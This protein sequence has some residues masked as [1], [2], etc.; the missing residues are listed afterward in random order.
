MKDMQELNKHSF[1]KNM[2]FA[3]VLSIAIVIC[4][5]VMLIFQINSNLGQTAIT[6][7]AIV[8]G[9][10]IIPLSYI[11]TI[12]GQKRI[13]KKH[14]F[15]KGFAYEYEFNKSYFNLRAISIESN[16]SKKIDYSEIIYISKRKECMYL[17]VSKQQAYIV[18]YDGFNNE[19]DKVNFVELMRNLRIK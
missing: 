5:I 12:F 11:A 6:I 10:L 7:M 9:S 1:F 2:I 13:L 18:K 19:N 3:M 16:K 17:Y 4:S 14:K 8:I 15:D